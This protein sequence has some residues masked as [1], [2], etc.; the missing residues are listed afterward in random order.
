MFPQLAQFASSMIVHTSLQARWFTG[1]AQALPAQKPP[2]EHTWLHDPQFA[3]SFVR[4]TQ[5]PLQTTCAPGHLHCPESQDAPVAH[6]FVQAPQW[7]TSLG[8]QTPSQAI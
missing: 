2:V 4:S 1:Q 7:L 3:E 5:V 8:M 6:L